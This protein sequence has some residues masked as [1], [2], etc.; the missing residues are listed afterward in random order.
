MEQRD[1]KEFLLKSLSKTDV[2][3]C[4]DCAILI[5]RRIRKPERWLPVLGDRYLSCPVCGELLV[6]VDE[7]QG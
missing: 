4:Q 1:S 3:Y 5:L 2:I 6:S 7:E